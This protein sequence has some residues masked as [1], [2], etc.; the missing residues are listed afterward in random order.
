MARPTPHTPRLTP[1]PLAQEH[2]D[3]KIELDF[4]PKVMH[5]IISRAS[6]RDEAEQAH[7][8]R[9]ATVREAPGMGLR[10]GFT[11]DEFIGWWVLR[12]PN[13]P[14]RPQAPGTPNSATCC[15]TGT[16]AAAT[17]PRVRAKSSATASPASA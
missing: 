12:P 6:T 4:N 15:C 7:K 10:L 16:D 2:L 8:R 17:P 11:E 3:L 5:Y 13:G 9:L 1:V 14:D